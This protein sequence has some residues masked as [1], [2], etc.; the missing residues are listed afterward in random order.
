MVCLDDYRK[1]GQIVTP[2]IEI[3]LLPNGLVGYHTIG[4]RDSDVFQALL[5]CY[6]VTGELLGRLR[7]KKE[8]SEG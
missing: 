7:E 6:A 3:E 8:C 2:K 4:L 5:G 1:K